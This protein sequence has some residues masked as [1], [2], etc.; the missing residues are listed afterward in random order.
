MLVIID[1]QNHILDP[2]SEFYLPDSEELVKRIQHRL[3]IARENQ[4]YILYTRDIPIE[5]KDTANEEQKSLQLIPELTPKN[6]ERIVKKYYFSIP[7]ETLVEIKKA[8]FD[9]K[10][11]QKNIEITGVETNLCV[12]SN[13]IEIQSA[14]PEADFLIDPALVSSRKHG[15][16]ALE[17]L[18][19]FN[20]QV[21]GREN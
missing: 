17:L 3:E 6:G 10:Q 2:E 1:M 5:Y 8:L 4:E 14:F 12:L 13:A 7:P 11:E 21:G 20:M 18:K 9:S 15:A 19:A 16:K